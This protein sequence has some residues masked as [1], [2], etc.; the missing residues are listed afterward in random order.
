[1]A[2]QGVF[3][4]ENN[5]DEIEDFTIR[6]KSLVTNLTMSQLGAGEPLVDISSL[7]CINRWFLWDCVK[8]ALTK[9]KI[10]VPLGFFA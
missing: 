7:I 9:V 4:K 2:S 6:N 8:T 1:M 10:S 3:K 5:S